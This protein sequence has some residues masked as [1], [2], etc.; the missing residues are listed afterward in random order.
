MAESD[1]AAPAAGQGTR[2]ILIN[3]QY[4][5]D[6]SFENPRAPQ[7]LVQQQGQQPPE[8][9][10]GIDVKAQAIAPPL[11]E[12]T[13]TIHAEANAGGERIFI[14][15][16]VYGAV[17]TLSNVAEADMPQALLVETPRLLFPFARSIVANATRD[18]GFMPLL[19]RPIDFAELYRQK[20]AAPPADVA[21]A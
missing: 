8:V 14:V 12:A 15:E 4:V 18:G 10:I 11:Y 17:V 2:E 9:K 21:T 6:L 16:L 20:M 5:K 13:L 1:G 7:S 19:M 3:A